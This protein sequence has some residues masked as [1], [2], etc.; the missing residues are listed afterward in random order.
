L[1][2]FTA[3]ESWAPLDNE[4]GSGKSGHSRP[5]KHSTGFEGGNGVVDGGMLR[6]GNA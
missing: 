3:R 2:N 6:K 5:T 4:V 1:I